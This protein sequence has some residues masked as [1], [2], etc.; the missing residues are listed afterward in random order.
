MKKVF[1]FLFIVVALLATIFPVP[2]S[3]REKT[4]PMN[5]L[6]TLIEQIRDRKLAVIDLSHTLNNKTPLFDEHEPEMVYKTVANY[7]HDGYRAGSFEML[8]HFGTHIDAPAHFVSS[9][10]T[11]D[12]LDPDKMIL[13]AVVIDV[14]D[15]VEKNADYRLTKE[16]IIAFEKTASI[17]AGSAVFLLTGWGH[18]WGDAKLYRNADAKGESRFPGFGIEAAKYLVEEKKIFALGIDTLS[19]DYGLSKEFDVHKLVL[20]RKLFMIEN[21]D[22]L[23][24]LPATGAVVFCGPMK[25][26]GGSGSPA[27]ILAVVPK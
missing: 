22:K 25:L 11:I 1:R 13:P 21:L 12:Q 27:R 6:S 8:E 9:N 14:R 5:C 4:E 7:E 17:P 16:K 15:E 10:P 2:A 23:D 20:G 3:A 24:L 18:R 26:E 19:I